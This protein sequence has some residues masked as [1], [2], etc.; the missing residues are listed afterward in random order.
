GCLF[1]IQTGMNAWLLTR[2]EAVVHNDASGVRA[3][4]PQ[5]LVTALIPLS[6]SIL[7]SSSAWLPLLYDTIVLGLTL[8]RTIPSIRNRNASYVMKRLLEDGLIYYSAIFIV[9]LVL[10]IMII[11]APP[12]LKNIAAQYVAM[13]SRITLNLKKSVHKPANTQPSNARH[14]SL[15]PPHMYPMS[16]SEQRSVMIIGALIEDQPVSVT[17]CSDR[18]DRHQ[19]NSVEFGAR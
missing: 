14:S 19:E 5:S 9:T 1:L 18:G 15:P 10:T 17:G 2:G 7:A 6:S 13:M 8:Y 4:H 16:G 12:G 11:A 3:K